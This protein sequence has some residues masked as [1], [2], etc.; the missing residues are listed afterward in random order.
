MIMSTETKKPTT[1]DTFDGTPDPPVEPP[2][3]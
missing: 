2:K 3:V 1:I